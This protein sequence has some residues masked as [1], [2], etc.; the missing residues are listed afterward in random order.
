MPLKNFIKKTAQ[1]AKSSFS[2]KTKKADVESEGMP[3]VPDSFLA[4]VLDPSSHHHGHPHHPHSHSHHDAHHAV[5]EGILE[6]IGEE[7]A[8]VGEQV[9]H[10]VVEILGNLIS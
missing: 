10:G 9:A 2:K 8:S 1:K 3:P 4:M 7:V 5:R 6:G